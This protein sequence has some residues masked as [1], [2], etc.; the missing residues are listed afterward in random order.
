ML[1]ERGQPV[2]D[3]ADLPALVKEAQQ[4]LMLHPAQ[5]TPD[6][7]GTDAVKKILG[8]VSAIAIGVA[9]H[10]RRFECAVA[11]DGGRTRTLACS[12]AETLMVLSE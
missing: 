10:T 4:A 6:P 5:A 12:P 7:D 3:R 8:G 2:D 11:V 9:G 1:I